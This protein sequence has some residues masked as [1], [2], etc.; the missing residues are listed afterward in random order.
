MKSLFNFHIPADTEKRLKRRIAILKGILRGL[1]NKLK[2]D[3]FA[4]KTKVL[5]QKALSR[6]HDVETEYSDFIADCEN[7]KP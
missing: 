7:K 4:I 5:R 6:L 2:I 3:P 1:D